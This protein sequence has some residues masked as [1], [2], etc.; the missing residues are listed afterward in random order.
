MRRSWMWLLG[1][2][3]AGLGG[4][5]AWLS[6]QPM[7]AGPDRLVFYPLV[8]FYSALA[9]PVSVV[10]LLTALTILG[11]W[12]PQALGRRPRWAAN[13]LVALLALAGGALACWGSLPQTFTPYRH[14]DRAVLNG[15]TYQL[16]LRAAASPP[17]FFFVLC[18]C[19]AAGLRCACSDLVETEPEAIT[20]IPRLIADADTNRLRVQVG[21][22]T[23][24]EHAPQ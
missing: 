21:E 1:A 6:Q 22:A 4:L 19:D 7:V 13:G 3:A 20:E 17:G 24:W 15:L 18:T 14:L 2:A 8:V 16:G 23:V 10:L 9:T 5:M 12:V 11:F